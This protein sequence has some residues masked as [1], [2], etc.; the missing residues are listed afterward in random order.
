MTGFVFF[1]NPKS[2]PLL[3]KRSQISFKM[4]LRHLNPW[5]TW[6]QDHMATT[7]WYNVGLFGFILIIK[8]YYTEIYQE[9]R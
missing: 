4:P 2:L 9:V 3:V 7:E 8:V 5:L 6:Q 1:L